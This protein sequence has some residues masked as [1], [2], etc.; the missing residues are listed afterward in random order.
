MSEQESLPKSGP[1]IYGSMEDVYSDEYKIKQLR[2]ELKA[3][4]E[5]VKELVDGLRKLAK[6]VPVNYF[7]PQYLKDAYA[8]ITKYSGDKN[9]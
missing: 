5:K 6:N 2:L 9:E 3:E 8:L 1:I 4:K 7:E